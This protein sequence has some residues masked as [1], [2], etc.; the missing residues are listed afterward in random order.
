MCQSRSALNRVIQNNQEEHIIM[1]GLV[2]NITVPDGD[3]VTSV[4][5]YTHLLTS[6]S[7]GR[8]GQLDDTMTIYVTTAKGRLFKVSF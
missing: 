1:R 2:T 4:F 5:S 8:E 3:E 6:D 7:N